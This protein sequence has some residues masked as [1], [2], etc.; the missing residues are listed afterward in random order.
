MTRRQFFSACVSAGNVLLITFLLLSIVG[1][2]FPAQ[3]QANLL[4]NPDFEQAFGDG[5]TLAAPPGWGVVGSESSG[6]VGRYLLRGTEVVAN[7]GINSGNGSFD[8]YK[9]WTAYSVSLYQT[10]GGI[11]PGTAVQASAFGRI[12]SCDSD[13]EAAIDGCIGGDGSVGDQLN[14]G[15]TFRVGIDPTGANDPNSAN[16]VWSGSTNPYQG[17]QQ[18]VVDATASAESVT[19]VLNASMQIPVRHQHVFWD[20]ASL[21]AG[22]SGGTSSGGS[23]AAPAAPAFAAEVQPQGPQEDG[24]IV[25]T[26]RSGDTLAGIAVAYNVTIPDLLALN[27][28]TADQARLIY[29]GQE[30]IVRGAQAGAAS[31]SSAEGA[32]SGE[33]GSA[34]GSAEGAAEAPPAETGEKP[35]ENY[36]PAP[37]AQ[38]DIPVLRLSDTASVGEICVTLFEDTNP[39]RLRESGEVLLAGGEV[40]V[41]QGGGVVGNYTTDGASEPYCFGDLTPGAYDVLV[42]APTGYGVTT[43]SAYDVRLSAGQTVQTVFGAAPG[44]T[45]PQPS[46]GQAGGLFSDESGNETDT[47]TGPLDQLLQ[48]SGVIVLGLAGVVLLGG[49]ILMVLLRR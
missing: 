47:R 3:A 17:F 34:E 27:D 18:M 20:T 11:Q 24:S 21:T 28:M 30:L 7:V 29:P 26:V 9:G 16:I 48:Y 45:P 25:H 22:G 10:V 8:A 42:T 14:T 19:I 39:N 13:A 5:V 12:W 15:A 44:F 41:S 33:E 6:L 43:A 49:V 32:S 40:V 36:D 1:T 35:I 38:A 4:N 37:V 31:D 23:A 2:Q 46:G